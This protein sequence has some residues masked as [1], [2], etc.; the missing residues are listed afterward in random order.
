MD[1]QDKIEAVR[2]VWGDKFYEDYMSYL[3]EYV[4]QE[5]R[6]LGLPYAIEEDGGYYKVVATLF[7]IRREK[8]LDLFMD[9]TRKLHESSGLEYSLLHNKFQINIPRRDRIQALLHE[10]YY[11]KKGQVQLKLPLPRE[12]LEGTTSPE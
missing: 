5:S 10:N 9:V 3:F 8:V 11:K 7:G 6:F 1:A 4:W 2:G 12:N